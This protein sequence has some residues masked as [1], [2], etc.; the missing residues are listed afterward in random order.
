[1]RVHALVRVY[2]RLGCPG[3]RAGAR[4][5][6]CVRERSR[7]CVGTH[8]FAFDG[9]ARVRAG[10]RAGVR[11]CVRALCMH[12]LRYSTIKYDRTIMKIMYP[13]LEATQAASPYRLHE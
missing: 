11:A 13:S 1:M 2:V 3:V 5:K 6:V 7:A 9:R 10:G 8:A 12:D 4:V